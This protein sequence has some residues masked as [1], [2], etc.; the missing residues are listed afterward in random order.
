MFDK[1]NNFVK[2]HWEKNTTI[3]RIDN[4]KWYNK[5][6]CRWATYKEQANN[7]SNNRAIEYNWK[8]Y[9]SISA[10]CDDL[11]LSDMYHPIVNRISRWRS[12]ERAISEDKHLSKRDS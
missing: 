5:E 2:I 9:K 10:M 8:Q 3:D 6:N 1:Y 11:W 7:S 12:I 4:N